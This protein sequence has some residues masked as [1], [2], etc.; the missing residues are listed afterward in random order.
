MRKRDWGIKTKNERKKGL[1]RE[2]EKEE[3]REEERKRK[4]KKGGREKA[5]KG[6][7]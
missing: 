4:R 7:K 5:G 2:Q 3:E 1:R 6:G